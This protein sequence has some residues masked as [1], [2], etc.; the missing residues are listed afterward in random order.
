MN[1]REF[2][3]AGSLGLVLANNLF[4]QNNPQNSQPNKKLRAKDVNAYL[5]SL[6]KVTEPS[7]DKVIIGDPE[8]VVK[9]MG[10]CW[11]PY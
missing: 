10:T 8:T 2:I 4:A 5:R 7:V 11:M 1:R 3:E 9:K 6:E